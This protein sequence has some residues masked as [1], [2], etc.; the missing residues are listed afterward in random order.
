MSAD[1]PPARRALLLGLLGTLAACAAPDTTPTADPDPDPDPDQVYT[2]G[3]I[4]WEN[5]TDEHRRRARQ[6]LSRLGET[7][8]DDATLQTR[9][10]T[11]SPAQQRFMIRRPPPPRPA[12]PART[13]A[14]TATPARRTTTTTPRRR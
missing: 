6:G 14:R 13:P 5:L 8:P 11:M 1:T 9:W 7:I 12:A 2:R 4:P 10:A 3:P